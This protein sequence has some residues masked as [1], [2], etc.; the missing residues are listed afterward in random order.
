MEA[1]YAVASGPRGYV[2]DDVEDDF[3]YPWEFGEEEK[4][5]RHFTVT[6]STMNRARE[7]AFGNA[8]GGTVIS[9]ET[10][11]AGRGRNGRRWISGRGG[12]FFTMLERP[13]LSI[14]NYTLLA[15]AAHIAVCRA[16]ERVCGINVFLRWPNDIYG[17][18]KKMAGL[19][20]E[21]YGKGD[22]V[23]WM[24]IGAGINVNNRL[25]GGAAGCAA[26]TGHVVSRRGMLL[27]VLDEF[28]K[29]KR[30]AADPRG[31]RDL[32]NYHAEG[33]GRRVVFTGENGGKEKSRGDILARGVF[34]GIDY[35]FRCMIQTDAEIAG[36][37]PAQGSLIFY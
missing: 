14:V 5:F 13:R 27:A 9:A 25:S 10:Q 18:G 2:L 21:V 16:I 30:A 19:L 35:S 36:F 33:I 22:S 34:L 23:E 7:C 15:M 28:G 3:L 17:G 24:A 4:F 20:S 12:L 6:D 31:I 32:W 37:L 8:P 26:L 11:T 29:I 1:G